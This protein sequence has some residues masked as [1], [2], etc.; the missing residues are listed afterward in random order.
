MKKT[1]ILGLVASGFTLSSMTASAT[2][3]SQYPASDFQPKVLFIDK[4]L[5][6]TA[7]KP[8]RKAEFDPKYPATHFEPKV[9]YADPDLISKAKP[10][11]KVEFD[12]KIL[13][14]LFKKAK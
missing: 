2:S 3:D 7:Q 6:A 9:V 1:L 14:P 5:A 12:P 10:P 8:A 4:E 13:D 11:R